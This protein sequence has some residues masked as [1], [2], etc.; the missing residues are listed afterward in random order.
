M[1]GKTQLP[2][3]PEPE[4]VVVVFE[5]DGEVVVEGEGEVEGDGEGATV[6]KPSL[7]TADSSPRAAKATL[8]AVMTRALSERSVTPVDVWETG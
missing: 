6:E 4:P 1:K 7:Q 2:Q 5:G 8:F 3:D